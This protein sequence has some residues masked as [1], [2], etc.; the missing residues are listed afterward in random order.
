LS[1]Q[2]IAP[3]GAD[4]YAPFYSGYV[5][6]AKEHGPLELLDEQRDTL[7]QMCSTL[8]EEQALARYAPGKWSIKQVL[9][10]LADTERIFSY[11]LFRI[12]RG[13]ATPLAGFD[14]NAYVDSAR[15]DE[16]PLAELLEEFLSVREATLRLVQGLTPEELAR[17]GTANEAAVSA[18]ALVYIAAGHVAHHIRILRESYGVSAP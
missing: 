13:D 14:Q 3:A 15:S 2:R 5:A 4:E 17:R 9:G 16:R 12:S 1:R 11:R 7:R 6:L 8:T 18:R 10:H